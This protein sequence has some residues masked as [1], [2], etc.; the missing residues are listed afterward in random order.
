MTPDPRVDGV[1]ALLREREIRATGVRVSGFDGQILVLEARAALLP[2][3][4][5]VAPAIKALGFRYVAMD[6]AHVGD[7]HD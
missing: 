6:L 4:A 1:H 7:H 3:L 5:L 2:R